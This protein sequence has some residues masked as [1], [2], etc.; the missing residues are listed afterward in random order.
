MISITCLEFSYTQAPNEM[1]SYIMGLYLLFSV[2]L[3]NQ[4]TARVNGFIEAREAA[5]RPLL[6]RADYYLFFTL[7]MAVTAAA[8][9]LW[10]RTYRGE[11]YLQSEQASGAA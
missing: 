6:Q 5:G 9:V 2:A 7:C 10:S 11:T 1:K 3:G 8:Y 4:F